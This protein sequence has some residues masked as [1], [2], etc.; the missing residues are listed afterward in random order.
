LILVTKF[1][2]QKNETY[3]KDEI[4]CHKFCFFDESCPEKGVCF[5]SN[6]EKKVKRT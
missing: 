5:I 1:A 2:L 4:L 6:D 3:R